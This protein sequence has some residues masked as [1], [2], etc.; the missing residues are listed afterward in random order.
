[1]KEIIKTGEYS[2]LTE[3]LKVKMMF[4]TLMNLKSTEC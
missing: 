2:G 1:M 4:R 3:L